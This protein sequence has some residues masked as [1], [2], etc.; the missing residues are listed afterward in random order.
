MP[1]TYDLHGLIKISVSGEV[2]RNV[3]DAVREQLTWLDPTDTSSAEAE[4]C[5]VPYD[6]LDQGRLTRFGGPGLRRGDHLIDFP[7]REIAIGF[8]INRITLYL[9]VSGTPVNPW[10][11]LLLVPQGVS[12]VHAAAVERDGD[13]LLL[14][15]FGGAGKT[16]SAG[17][18]VKNHGYRFLGDDIVLLRRDGTVLSFPRPLILYRH[19]MKVFG[20]YFG[21]QRASVAKRRVFGGLKRRVVRG[22]PFKSSAKGVL[23]TVGLEGYARRIVSTHEYYAAARA[24]DVFPEKSLGSS[25][26]LNRIVLLQRYSGETVEEGMGNE[27]KLA[28]QMFGIL[29]NEWTAEWP[30]I[31]AAAAHGLFDLGRYY[32]DVHGIIQG[33]LRGAA[34]STLLIPERCAP[35]DYV[36]KLVEIG[37]R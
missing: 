15:A 28:G 36:P 13:V 34:I 8:D 26:S 11:Q 32:H 17:L 10:L 30:A 6:S 18:L 24:Q 12:M 27:D 2:H 4:L 22:F 37:D 16:F 29:H 33:A 20:D 35:Q 25:G 19:H 23:R 5:L 7:G 14:P 21:N 1:T 31:V 9:G 3:R